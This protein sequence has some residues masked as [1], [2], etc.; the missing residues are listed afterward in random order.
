[1]GLITLVLL[2]ALTAVYL[3]R[4]LEKKPA[5]LAKVVALV[6]E[7]ADYFGIVAI[8]AAAAAVLS[9]VMMLTNCSNVVKLVANLM[10]IVMLLPNLVVKYEGLI[11]EKAGEK[12]KAQLDKVVVLVKAQEKYIGYAGAA[13]AA[14]MLVFMF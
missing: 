5:I 9:L 4:V 10:I 13:V 1:M 8:Y 2:L 7:N 12:V 6:D 3:N 14:L 11:V